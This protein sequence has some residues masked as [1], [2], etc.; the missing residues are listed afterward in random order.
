MVPFAIGPYESV[1]LE[2][3]LPQD[4]DGD[5]YDDAFSRSWESFPAG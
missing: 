5:H 2:C 3:T 4:H 1:K